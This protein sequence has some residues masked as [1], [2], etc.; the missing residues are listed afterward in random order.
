MTKIVKLEVVETRRRLVG[1]ATGGAQVEGLDECAAIQRL[2][3][4]QSSPHSN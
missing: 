2:F 4:V 1:V 3:R